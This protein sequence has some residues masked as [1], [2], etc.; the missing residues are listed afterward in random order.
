M[1]TYDLDDDNG[2][3][4][5]N[6]PA[7]GSGGRPDRPGKKNNALKIA[8]AA[9]SLTAIALSSYFVFSY[10]AA[11]QSAAIV[12]SVEDE[13]LPVTEQDEIISKLGRLEENKDHLGMIKYLYENTDPKFSKV[14]LPWLIERENNGYTPYLYAIARHSLIRNDPY[15]S[16]LYYIAAGLAARVDAAHCSDLTSANLVAL[17]ENGFSGVHE[18]M[19]AHPESKSLAGRFALSKEDSLRS[20]PE[21]DWLC[22]SGQETS[23][24]V[25]YVANEIWQQQ[26]AEIRVAFNSYIDSYFAEADDT[27]SDAAELEPASGSPNATQ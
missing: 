22:K 3:G 18:Y 16:L 5:K 9:I 15:Q 1:L 27:A 17:L 20:R 6:T 26:R 7:W 12:A 13:S 24:Y 11:E 23:P 4:N 19:A 21:P 25:P 8:V 14:V 2:D 10:K